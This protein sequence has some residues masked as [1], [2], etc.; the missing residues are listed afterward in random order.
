MD[1]TLTRRKVAEELLTAVRIGLLRATASARVDWR[2]DIFRGFRPN[3]ISRSVSL[4]HARLFATNPDYLQQL[5]DI[6]LDEL[7][8][9]GAFG[10]RLAAAAEDARIPAALQDIF[11]GLSTLTE[12]PLI[13]SGFDADDPSAPT[14]P[15]S[16]NQRPA[17][18]AAGAATTA[19]QRATNTPPPPKATFVKEP[20][21]W[22][23]PDDD[24]GLVQD[25][26]TLF[27]RSLSAFVERQLRAIHGDAWLRRGCGG[28]YRK[29]WAE[30]E[31][32]AASP[33]PA[34]LLGYADIAEMSEIIRAKEN[35][36]AFEPYFE[37]KTFLEQRFIQVF[38][39]RNAAAH[40]GQRRL[41][42]SEQSAAFAAMVRIASCYH[43]P[44]A[45]AIDNLWTPDEPE[46][47]S[48]RSD[49]DI[50]ANL[51]LK[52]FG[53]LLPS[54]PLVGREAD[55]RA[56]HEFWHDEF[57]KCISITG[58]GGLGKTALAYHFVN[59]LLRVPVQPDDE[60]DPDLVLF[61]TAK[62]NWAEQDNQELLPASQRFNA[63]EDA[64]EATLNLLGQPP[65]ADADF[66]AMRRQVFE[67]ANAS[68]MPLRF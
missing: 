4:K 63:L 34:T 23:P 58:R 51:I 32:R 15:E 13:P 26:V 64:F 59:D 8:I 61:V 40:P 1:T 45:D 2:E 53:G 43:P 41:Y 36:P 47:S 10:E 5:I 16:D 17:P 55:L 25:S 57:V 27:E 22:I 42:A 50:T 28:D 35:W 60:P 49:T 37:D 44:T 65:P 31:E 48:T 9:Q 24:T 6:Y 19:P 21:H 56:I 67:L 46:P 52:N 68:K 66:E 29:R 20:F 7:S 33:R 18:R 39:L 3:T 54:H 62:R 30:R 11:A 38:P 12:L 14:S